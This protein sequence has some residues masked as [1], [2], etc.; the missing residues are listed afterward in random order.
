MGKAKHK[1]QTH[2]G[3]PQG[4]IKGE[5]PAGSGELDPGVVKGAGGD[6]SGKHPPSYYEEIDSDRVEEVDEE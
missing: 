4:G 5:M 3:K 1:D 6:I 2:A